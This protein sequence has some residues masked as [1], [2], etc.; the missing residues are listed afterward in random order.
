LVLDRENFQ[1][2]FDALNQKGYRTCAPTLRDNAVVYDEISSVEELPIGYSD[3]QDAGHYRLVKSKRKALFDYVVGFDSWKKFLYP[4]SVK[5]LEA[6]RNGQQF[7]INHEDREVRNQAFIGV[8]PCELHAIAILDKVL[9]EGP[10]SDPV[11]ARSR[12]NLFIVAVNCTRPGGTCFCASMGTGPKADSGFDLAMTEIIGKDSHYFVV[13]VGSEAGA[14]LIKGIPCRPAGDDEIKLAG[15][16]LE[17]AEKSMGRSMAAGDI[18]GILQDNFDHPHW[19][20]VARRCLTCGCC[21]MVCPTCFCSTIK[22]VTDLSGRTG[23]RWRKMDSCFSVEFSYIYGGSVRSTPKSR[24]RQWM[25][26]KLANWI[27]Q[28]GTSG[29]VGCGRCITWCPVGI[30]IT[31]EVKVIMESKQGKNIHT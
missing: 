26:H 27:D 17:K 21:T 12:Q 22:D 11:Y 16:S 6:R 5:I 25:T 18:K 9:I 14:D 3:D 20:E 10:Y 29:C 13:E 15:K 7:E 31:E 8:R 23:Q 30:D 19:E 4:P 28:F 2:L 1:N 24:Y